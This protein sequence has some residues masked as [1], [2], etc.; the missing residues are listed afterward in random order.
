MA[1]MGWTLGLSG[2]Q[3]FVSQGSE[4]KFINIFGPLEIANL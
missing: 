1:T 3:V 4:V 2:S